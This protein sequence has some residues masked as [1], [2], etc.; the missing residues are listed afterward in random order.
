MALSSWFTIIISSV[1]LT[2][3]CRSCWVAESAN[4]IARKIQELEFNPYVEAR[5]QISNQ[6]FPLMW[7]H[8]ELY[9]KWKNLLQE[10]DCDTAILE[11]RYLVCEVTNYG[12]GIALNIKIPCKIEISEKGTDKAELS[13]NFEDEFVFWNIKPGE[14]RTSDHAVDITYF[15]DVR[16]EKLQAKI[17]GIP[18]RGDRADITNVSSMEFQY[19]ELEKFFMK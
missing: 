3:S 7:R 10:R 17:E 2:V 18:Q 5:F 12:K 11:K 6:R 14:T 19:P 1:A 8:A 15:P 13:D 9:K 16:V 4:S